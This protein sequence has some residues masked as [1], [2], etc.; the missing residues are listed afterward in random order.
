MTNDD[1]PRVLIVLLAMAAAF[2]AL[3]WLVEPGPDGQ[4]PPAT[5]AS[6]LEPEAP[7]ATGR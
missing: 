3:A 2:Y 7:G 4:P 5:A 1:E 6:L